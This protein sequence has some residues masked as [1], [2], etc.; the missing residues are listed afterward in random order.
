MQQLDYD[1]ELCFL[2]ARQSLELRAD[3][4]FCMGV[5][6]RGLEAEAEE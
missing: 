1:K 6:G 4:E 3:R 2:Q 5:C